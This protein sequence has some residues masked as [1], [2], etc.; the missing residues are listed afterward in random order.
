M[1]ERS[2]STSTGI[3][4]GSAFAVVLSWTTFKSFWWAVLHGT[5][6]WGYVVYYFLIAN[7]DALLP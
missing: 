5:F 7:H 6:G 1:S 2:G 3:S 4:L